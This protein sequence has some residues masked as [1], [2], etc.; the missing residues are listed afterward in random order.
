[1]AQGERD[2][3]GRFNPT[4]VLISFIVQGPNTGDQKNN[5]RIRYRTKKVNETYHYLTA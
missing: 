2:I 3:V 4:V 5:G 1:M